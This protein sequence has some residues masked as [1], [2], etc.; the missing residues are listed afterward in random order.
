LLLTDPTVAEDLEQLVSETVTSFRDYKAS[1]CN[2]LSLEGAGGT[3][4]LHQYARQVL[5][6]TIRVNLDYRVLF[7]PSPEQALNVRNARANLGHLIEQETPDRSLY[8]LVQLDRIG[9]HPWD[10]ALA[11]GLLT[12]TGTKVGN[13][14]HDA[15]T[16]FRLLKSHGD[17]VLARPRVVEVPLNIVG[18]RVLKWGPE[19]RVNLPDGVGGRHVLN[20]IAAVRELV[21]EAPQAYHLVTM[22]G[23]FE[24]L[25][26]QRIKRA[27]Q[28]FLP[29]GQVLCVVN[30]LWPVVVGNSA[31]Y[32]VCDFQVARE[33]PGPVV[34]L[35]NQKEIEAHCHGLSREDL[36]GAVASIPGAAEVQEIEE[37][38]TRIRQ[39]RR[40]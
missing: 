38:L 7:L 17:F 8:V 30:R 27:V 40:R 4:P 20:T 24:N 29:A 15:V 22:M 39:V 19:H 12:L 21:L 26:I 18:T 32:L 6:D 3:S 25:D 9:E 13:G 37:A 10:A 35:L 23:A 36:A 16:M 34:A 33:V 2:L 28:A 31:N 1:S 5:A 11:A 14:E